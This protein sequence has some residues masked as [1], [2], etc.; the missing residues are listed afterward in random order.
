M[1]PLLAGVTD[2]RLNAF[3][4]TAQTLQFA[5][6]GNFCAAAK[7]YISENPHGRL[8]VFCIEIQIPFR[9]TGLPCVGVCRDVHVICGSL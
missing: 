5:F 3:Y 6:K 8:R 2:V 7:F 1:Y 4:S 9:S